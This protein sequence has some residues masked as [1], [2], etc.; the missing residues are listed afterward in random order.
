MWLQSYRN[1]IISVCLHYN[2]IRGVTIQR[3]LLNILHILISVLKCSGKY[4]IKFFPE[5]ELKEKIFCIKFWYKRKETLYRL[6][7]K[8][9]LSMKLSIY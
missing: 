2:L 1:W 7:T 8:N 6:K 9:N 3:I 5:L 4:L